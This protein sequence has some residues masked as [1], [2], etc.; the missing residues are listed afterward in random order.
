M[1]SHAEWQ[2]VVTRCKRRQQEREQEE[3]RNAT[4]GIESLSAAVSDVFQRRHSSDD[5][6]D[7]NGA[8]TT[9]TTTTTTTDDN[10]VDSEAEEY[11]HVLE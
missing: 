4:C 6:L 10:D 7:M 2:D 9:T 11:S 1:T 3:H 5:K 8:T